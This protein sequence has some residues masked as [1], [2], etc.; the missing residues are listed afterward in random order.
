MA[1]KKP[2]EAPAGSP[3][4][5]ATFSDLMNLLLCFFVLLFSMSSVDAAKY[6][7]VVQSLASA[8]SILSSGGSSV[9]A[10]NLVS[11][12]LSQLPELANYFGDSMG[13]G[14]TEDDG[15]GKE[16]EGGQQDGPESDWGGTDSE[17]S[18]G[19][20]TG[21]GQ[22]DSEDSSQGQPSE[23][24][25][26]GESEISTEEA[27]EAVAQ[28]EL[29]ESEKMAQDIEA[30]TAQYG[31]QDLVEVDFNGEYVRITLNGGL[32]FESGSAEL[33]NDAR[34]L[35]EKIAKIIDIYKS[36]IVEV[37][38]HTD[39]VPVSAG[40]KFE[41]ND[42]LSMYRALYVADFLRDSSTVPAANIV[43]SGRGDYV[44]IADNGTAE[45]RARNRRVEIKIYN[46]FNSQ[47][48]ES[49]E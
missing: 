49:G 30:L 16:G 5:M 25:N 46:S 11:A 29:N 43:S 42:V 24:N 19:R 32:L 8:F 6:D 36:N 21:G 48:A 37:E 14:E 1:K 22:T 23:E 27:M 41:S 9:T 38:G 39:N 7:M 20:N 40:S 31:I 17:S 45:G 4:W 34:P 28:R 3:A 10:G 2:E 47:G 44:P 33:T 35:I 12:G 13:N 26:N 18:S 15:D